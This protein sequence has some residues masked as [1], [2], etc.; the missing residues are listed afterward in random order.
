LYEANEK[1]TNA[2]NIKPYKFLVMKGKYITTQIKLA[3]LS[4]VKK[5]VKLAA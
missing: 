4:G 5:Q 2:I 3:V 1:L